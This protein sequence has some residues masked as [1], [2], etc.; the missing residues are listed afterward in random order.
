MNKK[1]HNKFAELLASNLNEINFTI[2][3]AVAKP[4]WFE[5]HY[6]SK[7][8]IWIG[9]VCFAQMSAIAGKIDELRCEQIVSFYAFYEKWMKKLI[10][11]TGAYVQWQS[12]ST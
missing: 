12:I 5:R 4:D 6:N 7:L 3:D 2:A 8:W 10:V 9:N 11:N 1:N